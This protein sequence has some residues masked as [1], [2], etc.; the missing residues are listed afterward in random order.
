METK[1]S[2]STKYQGGQGVHTIEICAW[3][4]GS[5]DLPGFSLFVAVAQL[6]TEELS[7]PCH[8]LAVICRKSIGT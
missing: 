6:P 5:L 7:Q 4:A 2:L 1:I 3:I 8:F